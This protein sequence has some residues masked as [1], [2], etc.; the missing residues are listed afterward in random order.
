[1]RVWSSV[2]WSSR[3]WALV[4]TMLLVAVLF[5][6]QACSSDEPPSLCPS[7]PEVMRFGFYADYSPI[8]AIDDSDDASGHVGYEADLLSAIERMDNTNLSFERVAIAEWTGIWL[9]PATDRYEIVGGG[10]SILDARVRDEDGQVVVGFSR[11]H[12]DFRSSLLIRQEDAARISAPSDLAPGDVVGL[13][14]NTTSESWL[15]SELGIVDGDGVLRAGTKVSL[16]AGIVEADGSDRYT[17]G[18]GR[19]SPELE[20]RRAIT[21]ANSGVESGPELRYLDDSAAAHA[22]LLEGGVIDAIADDTIATQWVAQQSSGSLTVVGLGS[23]LSR[24]GFVLAAGDSRLNC[25]NE[26]IRWLTDDGELEFTAWLADPQIFALR[27]DH[28][29]RER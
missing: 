6:L 7:S 17:I 1:M 12:I 18:P 26:R 9:L 4:G 8:S 11:G 21:I 3:V 24:G 25:L 5:M 10:I 23:D 14:R 13:Y 22:R 27:A 20:G 15:L 19:S 2:E 28:W 16:E 29:N